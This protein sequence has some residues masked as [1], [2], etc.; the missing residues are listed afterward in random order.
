LQVN[1]PYE[2]RVFYALRQQA[3]DAIKS[4]REKSKVVDADQL[5]RKADVFLRMKQYEQARSEVK[6]ILE[7][8]K[9]NAVALAKLKEIEDF[10]PETKLQVQ[11]V[12]PEELLKQAGSKTVQVPKP[13]GEVAVA[14]PVVPPVTRTPAEPVQKPMRQEFQPKMAAPKSSLPLPVM[15]GGGALLIVALFVLYLFLKPKPTV[16]DVKTTDLP[17]QTESS[18]TNKTLPDKTTTTVVP[19]AVAVSIDVQPWGNVEI[20]GGSLRERLME[21]TPT[22]VQLPPGTYSVR[23]E[24]SQ[25]SAFTETIHVDPN[26]HEFAFR[27]PQFNP[28][29]LAESLTK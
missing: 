16:D 20:S 14:P 26:R 5:L 22:V 25:F 8:D 4:I 17:K 11:P 13:S 27:F 18:T 10:I 3:E 7:L 2:F 28:D 23:F 21:T 29:E 12:L 19:A 24:N 1:P 6:K 9:T 15:I